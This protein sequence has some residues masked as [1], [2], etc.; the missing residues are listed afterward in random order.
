MAIG[1]MKRISNLPFS[2]ARRDPMRL[3]VAKSGKDASRE[4]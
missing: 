4:N 3:K 1:K 2:L